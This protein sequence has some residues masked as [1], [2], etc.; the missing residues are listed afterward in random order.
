M[1]LVAVLLLV[2]L[3]ATA[4]AERLPSR[5]FTTADGLS[6]NVVNR[7]VRDT[8]G[9]QWFCTR[10]GL[11]MFDGNRFVTYGTEDGLPGGDVSDIL[12][13]RD[14]I[15]WVATRLGLVRFDP[16]G[17]RGRGS[18]QPLF[19]IVEP[20]KPSAPLAI[21]ALFEDVSGRVWVGTLRGLYR[22]E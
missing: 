14:G 5:V 9:Y 1:I 17:M 19:S 18:R 12:E 6:N 3:P 2:L 21:S 7:I 15:Y 4:R 13:T 20:T 8:R 11:S 10:E 22:L 16:L